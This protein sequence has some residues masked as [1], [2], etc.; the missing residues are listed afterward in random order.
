MF[1][2]L[3]VCIESDAIKHKG[4]ECILWSQT[5]ALGTLFTLSSPQ[6]PGLQNGHGHSC[7]IEAMLRTG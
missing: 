5:G 2:F 4:E 1:P 3:C 6:F 7:L